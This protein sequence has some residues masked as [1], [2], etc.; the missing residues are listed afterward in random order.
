MTDRIHSLTV[1]LERDNRSDD[2]EALVNAI[3]MFHGVLSVETH[4]SDITSHM[5]EERARASLSE[6]IYK[7]LEP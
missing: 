5:A 1:V 4:V 2:V 3:R 6:K 7:A